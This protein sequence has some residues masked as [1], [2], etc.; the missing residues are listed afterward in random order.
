[1]MQSALY[2][3]SINDPTIPVLL[4]ASSIERDKVLLMDSFFE[5]RIFLGKDVVEWFAR[6]YQYMNEYEHIIQL[7]QAPIDAQE[8]LN[9]RLPRPRFLITDEQPIFDDPPS[10]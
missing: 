7:L 3:Y 6:K 8:I 9:T 5:V 2:R 4:H 10:V 1:M